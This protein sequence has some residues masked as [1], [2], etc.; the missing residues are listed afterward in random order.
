[1]SFSKRCLIRMPSGQTI[2][3]LLK[4]MYSGERMLIFSRIARLSW[5]LT[6]SIFLY[7]W[8][9]TNIVSFLLLFSINFSI[10]LSYMTSLAVS[11]SSPS[12][13]TLYKSYLGF[14][15]HY[16]A[17]KIITEA[18]KLL[19]NYYRGCYFLALLNWLFCYDSVKKR[20][21]SVIIL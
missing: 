1:M 8:K 18:E 11:S 13:S 4:N 17:S 14:L 16:I 20:A 12:F 5:A 21:A 3:I 10:F 9:S 2:L 7:S 19:H 15:K 6:P